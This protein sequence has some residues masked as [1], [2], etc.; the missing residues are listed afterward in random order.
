MKF[1]KDEAGRIAILPFYLYVMRT[2]SIFVSFYHLMSLG[3]NIVL[4]LYIILSHKLIIGP[5]SSLFSFTCP[6]L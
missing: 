5:F 1:E 4:W 2:V 6:L 3:H